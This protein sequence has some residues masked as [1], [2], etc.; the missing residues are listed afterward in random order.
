MDIRIGKARLG[1]APVTLDGEPIGAYYNARELGGEGWEP[2]SDLL[3]QHGA[4]AWPYGQT[5]A[6]TRRIVAAL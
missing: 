2:S 1:S 3:D 6:A 5:L 4:I